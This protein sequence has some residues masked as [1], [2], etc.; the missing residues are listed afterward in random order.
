MASVVF[1]PEQVAA[2]DES[3]KFVANPRLAPTAAGQ[4][5]QHH[6][7]LAILIG[8]AAT[9]SMGTMMAQPCQAAGG[10][11]NLTVHDEET[12][13]PTI[14]RVEI[15]RL[16][17]PDKP[18]KIRKSVPAGMG[19]VLDRSLELSLPDGGY[20]FRMIRGPEYRIITGNFSLEKASL[21]EHNVDLP[22]MVNMR[23]K[24]WTSGDACV[25]ASPNSLPLRMVSEDLHLAAVMGHVDAKPIPRRDRDDPPII[26]PMWIRDDVATHDG[27]A[28]YGLD[29]N[30]H[31]PS[32]SIPSQWIAATSDQSDVQIAIENPF[33]WALPIWLASERIDGFFVLG[34]WL[35]L[36]R[37]VLSVRS[38]QQTQSLVK[39][40]HHAVG[41]WAE[42]IYWK[43][44]DA[45]FRIAPL[46]GS[47]D[48]SGLS[49]IGY[50]RLYVAEPLESYNEDAELEAN[51]VQ[52]E[53]NWWR[54]AWA[55]Q[56]VATNGPMLR[57]VL[58]GKIPGHVF[59]ATTG[60]AL[61]MH[62]EVRLATRDPVDYLEV[63]QNGQV[64][65]KARLDEFAKAGGI[66]PPLLIKESSWVMMRVVTLHDD[67]YRIATSAP[68][69]IDFDGHRRVTT[70]AVLFFQKWQSDYEERLKRLPPTEL[71]KHIPYV[72][73]AREFWNQRLSL[74]VASQP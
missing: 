54:S 31:P 6:R 11:L 59:H 72:K 74:Q 21:D 37:K 47:G 9:L 38:G 33:A 64:H 26:D 29:P 67:H 48:D 61:E 36:D 14:T 71:A 34:D 55:G 28:F 43:L 45:G 40:T 4:P 63:I 15:F 39:G 42:Q 68:W 22:R 20:Q 27:L 46:A 56:S 73:A 10:V 32:E 70:D 1:K 41:R 50:N 53:T 8:L 62:P 5:N 52:S 19:V 35:R 3:C 69:Y 30:Q 7:G 60:E 2:E 13:D 49:P 65:Y 17:Q 25:T 16:E 57:P 23:S 18:M 44:L 12:G 51:P 58:A 24:G 66:I